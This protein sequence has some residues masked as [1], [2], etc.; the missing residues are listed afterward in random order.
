MLSPIA[1]VVLLKTPHDPSL[2]NP[3]LVYSRNTIRSLQWRATYSWKSPRSAV[4][5][6]AIGIQQNLWEISFKI[7]LRILGKSCTEYWM[8]SKVSIKI[9]LS[10]ILSL[11]SVC[12]SGKLL[13]V[14]ASRVI[15][16]SGTGG[17]C[18]HIFLPHNTDCFV[19][20]SPVSLSGSGIPYIY[21][22]R[23]GR[24]GG[25]EAL[26]GRKREAGC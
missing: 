12:R 15:I 8:L 16:V 2:R 3:R 10:Y 4:T 25:N 19:R 26:I 5:E 24:G 7:R 6:S 22:S 11:R 1:G 23:A 13:M 17:I 9:A 14:F 20:I 18:D 21:I